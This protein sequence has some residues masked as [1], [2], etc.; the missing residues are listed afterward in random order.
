[1]PNMEGGDI[2]IIKRRGW[3]YVETLDLEWSILQPR[4]ASRLWM[5][6]SAL[7]RG[8][9]DKKDL[10][11]VLGMRNMDGDSKRHARIKGKLFVKLERIVV[12][13]CASSMAMTESKRTQI[14]SRGNLELAQFLDLL[15][16]FR[17]YFISLQGLR[18]TYLV[19]DYN[20]TVNPVSFVFPPSHNC[21]LNTISGVESRSGFIGFLSSALSLELQSSAA[22][23]TLV[24]LRAQH[25]RRIVIYEPVSGS[26]PNY[27]LI[28]S[29]LIRQASQIPALQ[30][31]IVFRRCQCAQERSPAV[32][33]MVDFLNLAAGMSGAG[34]WKTYHCVMKDG[35]LG[36]WTEGAGSLGQEDLALDF[37]LHALY[38]SHFLYE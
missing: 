36:S 10:R 23:S 31:V 35:E 33:R 22:V 9:L 26:H 5:L 8:L 7:D 16:M 24:G 3:E 21:M 29:A 27:I 15:V 30:D 19:S 20:T 17:T 34:K 11:F 6:V 18:D 4:E 32:H 13:S 12:R 37:K 14:L 25:L 1:M 28:Y 38:D 2:P